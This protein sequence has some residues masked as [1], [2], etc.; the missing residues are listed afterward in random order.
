MRFFCPSQSLLLPVTSIPEAHGH[1]HS[2]F[3]SFILIFFNGDFSFSPGK[4]APTSCPILHSSTFY[5]LTSIVVRDDAVQTKHSIS[6][7]SIHTGNQ[8]STCESL[9]TRL[10]TLSLKI[11]DSTL[12][13]SLLQTPSTF[14][15][16][17]LLQE[18]TL[19]VARVWAALLGPELV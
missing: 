18:Q 10:L 16:C 17:L 1:L 11:T 5:Q 8:G 3:L 12:R 4:V 13:K 6:H 19:M 2:T 14:L 9:L 15:L 7:P